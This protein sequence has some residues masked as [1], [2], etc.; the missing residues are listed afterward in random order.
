MTGFLP[1][2]VY[3]LIAVAGSLMAAVCEKRLRY[4][5]LILTVASLV[6]VMVFAFQK[7]LERDRLQQTIRQNEERAKWAAETCQH[8]R[9]PRSS[10][11]AF[12]SSI[13]WRKETITP[14]GEQW[15]SALQN[16][17]T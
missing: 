2:I 11:T 15:S 10:L 9:K 12:R 7:T 1:I 4:L 17:K 14:A 3:A 13:R 5:G 6:G 16:M 8:L